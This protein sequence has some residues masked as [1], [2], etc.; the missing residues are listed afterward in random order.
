ML[1]DVYLR[2]I[3]F[4]INVSNPQV[5]RNYDLISV[6]FVLNKIYFSICCFYLKNVDELYVFKFI[7]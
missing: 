3:Y 4:Y 1:T 7:F 6:V 2:Y 5:H